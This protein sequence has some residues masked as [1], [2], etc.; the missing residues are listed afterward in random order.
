MTASPKPK[1]IKEPMPSFLMKILEEEPQTVENIVAT[2]EAVQALSAKFEET[3]ERYRHEQVQQLSE[4]RKELQVKTEKRLS[5]MEM[6]FEARYV[7]VKEPTLL[8]KRFPQLR[9]K[10]VTLTGTR[11]L[12]I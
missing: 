2:N 8:T 3:I 9:S 5:E 4:I 6:K 11:C 1:K 12:V 10:E 7:R